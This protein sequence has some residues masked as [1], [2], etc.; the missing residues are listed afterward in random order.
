MKLTWLLPAIFGGLLLFTS[1]HNDPAPALA[2][3]PAPQAAEPA[4]LL[5]DVPLFDAA[6]V[7]NTPV[8][9]LLDV[10]EGGRI[11]P[12]QARGTQP[13]NWKPDPP[14]DLSGPM[15]SDDEVR[16]AIVKA[17][18][19][20]LDLQKE[21]GSWDVVLSG[22]LLSETADQ[23]VDAIAATGLAGYALRRHIKVNPE[24]IEPALKRAAQFVIDRVYR[25]KLPL[26]VWY[27]NWRYTLGLKFLHQEY[28]NTTDQEFRNE[29]RSV[30]RR[31]VQGLLKLQ[32][33][34]S[35]APA[36]EKKRRTRLSSRFKNSAMPSQLGVVLAP[37]TDEDYR[38]G[39]LVLRVLPG[40]AAERTGIKAGDRICETEGLRV[41]NSLDYYMQEAAFVGGQKINI[42][43][44]REGAKDF[45]KDVQLDQTWPGYLG[46]KVNAGTGEGPV[47]EA[48]L[49]FSPCKGELEVGDIIVEAN[50]NAVTAIDQLREIE[51]NI[52]PGDKVRLKVLRGEKSKKKSASVEATG[53]PEGWFYF[54]IQEEDKGDDNGVVVDGD[55]APGSPA[56]EAGLKDKDRITWIGDT[57]ILGMDHLIEFAG[58]VAAGKPYIVKW[59]RDGQEMQAEVSARAIPQPFNL[60]AD[61]DVNRGNL[62]VF[63]TSVEAGGVAEKAGMKKGDVINKINGQ[64]CSNYF[65]FVRVYYN[66]S[67]GEEVTFTMQRGN[68]EVE[69]KFELPKA[70]ETGG[71]QVAEEGGW[72]YYPEMGESPSFSTAAA[73]LVLMDVEH[74][75]EIK[76]LNRV[77]KEPMAA[78]AALM[79]KLRVVDKENG[80]L[81]T[82][83]YRGGSIGMGQIGIDVKGC[84]GRNAI[85]ELT[86]VRMGVA[87]RSKT[88][89]KKIIEQWIKYRGELD[90]VKRMEYY[91]PPGKGGSPHNFDR[92][93]N[94]AYYWMYGH[95]HTLLASK[96]VGGKHFEQINEICTKALM[97]VREDDGTWLGHPSFG[98]LCGTCLALWIL[99]ETEGGWRDGYAVPTTQ[100]KKDGGPAN[101]ETPDK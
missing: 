12:M 5:P 50:G 54:G 2:V 16:G 7:A 99:G 21:N 67:A 94:A 90:A 73:M 76:G 1:T 64:D 43:V 35:E 55:P 31:M 42:A 83:V 89:L 88:T 80:G 79:N 3:Q 8:G 47:V 81:E 29:L 28:M 97:L 26:Q 72:A 10:N 75:M 30:C 62:K 65:L 13:P 44:R 36:L 98:K 32:L 48:F 56:A 77:L 52:K 95:Y 51:R 71:E 49:P 101:P 92:H 57:P 87:K 4:A 82:Y 78:A 23:A 69:V 15:P 9:I 38:G 68:N 63:V 59:V 66:L 60:T 25:G 17:V 14:L 86:L 22:S 19:Y 93:F 27:A 84:Q 96:E 20:V 11:D 45:K 53:A 18:N 61:L 91:N 70:P 37:P 40:S 39:A 6:A 100:E 46:I 58:T 74:D 24:R 34:N 41:E 33:S 85:C